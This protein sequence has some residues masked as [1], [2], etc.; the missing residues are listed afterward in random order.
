MFLLQKYLPYSSKLGYWKTRQ[1]YIKLL[2][3]SHPRSTLPNTLLYECKNMLL[4]LTLRETLELH[5]PQAFG[6]LLHELSATQFS[7]KGMNSRISEEEDLDF[8]IRHPFKSIAEQYSNRAQCTGHSVDSHT[9]PSPSHF[10]VQCHS[11]Q[12][13]PRLSECTHTHKIR[14]ENIS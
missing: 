13:K 7:I 14:R 1:I 11:P 8:N 10:G 9:P 6:P 3:L 4:F 2:I 5:C 12:Q